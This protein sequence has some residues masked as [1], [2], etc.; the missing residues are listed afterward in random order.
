MTNK[1]MRVLKFGGTSVGSVESI[2][3]VKK[4]VEVI[5]EPVVVVVSALGGITDKLIETSRLA[6]A[7][8]EKYRDEFVA[9]YKRHFDMIDAIIPE[10]TRRDDLKEQV[11]TMFGELKSIYHGV[12]LIRDM[13]QKTANVI[14][15]YG[16]RMSSH[17]VA[18]LIDGAVWRDSRDF[19]KTVRKQNKNLVDFDTT[20][21]LTAQ[22]FASMPD[23]V[24][25]PGFIAS[26]ISDGETTNL[27]RGGSDYTAAIIAAA[28][29]AWRLKY[30]LMLTDL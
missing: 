9:M 25:V 14:V 16:E 27:G 8:N 28:A 15:S 30:G 2:T 10:G 6:A 29:N 12:F 17:I 19:I 23:R 13:T 26:D 1:R 3:N 11:Q 21:R 18:A 5:D 24:I 4:I 22:L 20:L 7:G